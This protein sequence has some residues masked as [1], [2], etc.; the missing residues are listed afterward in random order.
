MPVGG[1]ECGCRRA[2]RCCPAACNGE[3]APQGGSRQPNVSLNLAVGHAPI[4]RA[5]RQ[6]LQR[7][8][9]RWARVRM[10]SRRMLPPSGVATVRAHPKV[11]RERRSFRSLCVGDGPINRAERQPAQAVPSVGSECG[12]CRAERCCP[13]ACN[14]ESAPQGGSRQPNVSLNLAVGHAPIDRAGRQ[15]LQRNARRW[16]RVRMPSRG[17]LLP[18][19]V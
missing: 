8:A 5:G 13:A 19:R 6:R 12:C 9:R 2:E 7:N 16:A 15:R 3:S 10:L 11:G 17:T 1:P 4:D 14:G 18:S